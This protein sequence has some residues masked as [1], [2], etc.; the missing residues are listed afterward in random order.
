MIPLLIQLYHL[1]SPPLLQVPA[2]TVTSE[3]GVFS[4]LTEIKHKTSEEETLISATI[5]VCFG[6]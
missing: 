1:P 5:A 3:I 6:C 2:Y 4:L